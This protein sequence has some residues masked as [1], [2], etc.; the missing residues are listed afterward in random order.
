MKLYSSVMLTC[1]GMGRLVDQQAIQG[2]DFF[3]IV[4]VCLEKTVCLHF[5]QTYEYVFL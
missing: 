5:L 3:I 4:V 2:V 1:N